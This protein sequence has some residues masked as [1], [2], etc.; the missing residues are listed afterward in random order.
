MFVY[1]LGDIVQISVFLV[2]LIVVLV[3]ILIA[4]LEDRKRFKK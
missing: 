3:A 4:Y 2:A 1:T